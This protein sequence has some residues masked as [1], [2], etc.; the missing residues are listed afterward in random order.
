MQEKSSNSLAMS[1]A[2]LKSLHLRRDVELPC[3][4]T[5][6]IEMTFFCLKDIPL[7]VLFPHI[8]SPRLLQRIEGSIC[9]KKCSATICLAGLKLL[10]TWPVEFIREKPVLDHHE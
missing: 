9:I 7:P 1:I 8:N 5:I 2:F 3:S 6:N 10:K 4:N